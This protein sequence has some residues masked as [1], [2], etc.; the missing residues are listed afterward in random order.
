L[1]HACAVRD[2]ASDLPVY[3]YLEESIADRC[4]WILNNVIN[5]RPTR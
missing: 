3:G 5:S 1:L 2:T 4:R